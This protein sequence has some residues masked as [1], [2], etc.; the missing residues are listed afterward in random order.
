VSWKVDN[1][2]D[3]KET[4]SENQQVDLRM[5]SAAV[6]ISLPRLGMCRTMV[7]PKPFRVIF[8]SLFAASMLAG[9]AAHTQAANRIT[10]AIDPAN[11]QMLANHHPLWAIPANDAGALPANQPIKNVT[12]VLARSAEQEQA[13]DQ[14]LNEQQNP[15]SPEFHHW[16]TPIEMGERFGV[17]DSDIAAIT[18][19][20]QSEGLHVDWVA[21]NRILIGFGGS[22]ANM[23]R[24]FQTEFHYYKIHGQQRMSPATDPMIPTGVAPVIKA[25]R[26]LYTVE[27]RPYHL[28]TP[29]HADA[30]EMTVTNGSE[31]EHFVAP[32]DFDAIY[33]VPPSITGAG[34][35]I[36]IVGESRTD[37]ADFTNF[38]QL[39]G[40]TF[41][42]PTEI[43]PTT[44]GGTD[45][46]T[47]YT[48]P[49]SCETTDTCTQAVD[50]LLDAQGEAT[51]D[52]FRS[53]SVAPGASILLVT[54]SAASGGIGDDVDYLVDTTPAPAQVISISFGACEVEAGANN[55]DFWDALFKTA[56]GEGISVFVASGD[57]GASGCDAY[58]QT[59]PTD[60]EP[61]SPN[62]ICSSSYATCVG[63]TEFADASNPAAY[64]SSSDNAYLT[65]ALGYIP[66]GAWNE[67]INSGGGT[68][69]A[70]TGGGVSAYIATP[71]W[72]TGN[73]VPSSR[74]GRYTPDVAFSAAGHDGYFGC[75]AA[76]GGNCVSGSD[77]FT[78]IVFSG[79]SA[80]APSMAGVA[81]LLDQKQGSGQGNLNPEIYSLAASTPAAFHAVSIASSGVSDCSVT[82]PSMCNNSIPSPTALTGGQAGYSL[83]ATG[84]YSEVT[85][86]G[87]L[88]VAQ[89]IDDYSSSATQITPTVSLSVP[90][91]TINTTQSLL[92]LVT[93]NGGTGNPAPTG[94]ITLT[95][96]TFS[97]QAGLSDAS[98]STNSVTLTVPA[99]SLAVGTDTLTATYTSISS[100]YSNAT[101]TATVTVTSSSKT[102]PAISWS[103]PSAI[104]YGTA[105]SATQLD[106]TT[107]VAGNFSYSPAAGAVLTAGQQTLSVTFTPTDTTDYNNATATVTLTVNKATP[108][109]SW[110]TPSPITYGTALG[111]AQLDATASTAGAINYSPAAGTVLTAGLQTLAASFAPSDTTD[112]NPA[113]GSVTLTVNK[114]TPVI[115]WAAPAAVSAG[116]AL[117]STQLDATASV[118]GV[119]VYSPAAGAVMSIVGSATLS[120][121]F[122]PNDSTDY[123]T[124]TDSVTLVVNTPVNPSFALGGTNVSLAPGSTTGDTSTITVTPAGG[125]TGSVTLTAAITQSPTGVADA[126]T[127]SF[128]STSPL[129]ISGSNAGT[130]TL[131]ITT[132]A[133][134]TSA[135]RLANPAARLRAA[136]GAALA[137]VLL[138][139]LP[140]RRRGW[141]NLLGMAVL[142]AALACG[143]TACGG[144]AANGGAD[145]GG[146]GGGGGG[147]NGNPGTTAGTYTITVTGASG[148]TNVT[149]TI[150]LTVT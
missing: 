27:D 107:S 104:T 105:L 68:Q 119:F 89:F 47:A 64:W 75:F 63:G 12:L 57:A 43:I 150:T 114:A 134:T 143:M 2:Q 39:T 131:T 54:A 129:T 55:V 120:V 100:T 109:V 56:V 111:A 3:S 108:T 17:S 45:P 40:S 14:L 21:S 97:T 144:G 88:D 145:G 10:Q 65:S 33:D 31:T 13:L 116:T 115:T 72:Q 139:W 67:P 122:T 133:A 4:T 126:P 42:D 61:N 101:G 8:F 58:F 26:G 62:Y 106:A 87:S 5:W 35:T 83:G 80:A 121:T 15:A 148:S 81:A 130:A 147:G 84:G 141:R 137:C 138:F 85:G 20:L 98:G 41:P 70:A 132:T 82:T 142:L 69:A 66:E 50:S 48:A 7:S 140:V 51:L 46:G 1:S 90:G 127:L 113:T 71:S 22:A 92:V 44:Y 6:F 9:E 25:V 52:V 36:G 18:G 11:V 112:Y 77:G 124:A 102:T 79:T 118:P 93:V 59:P 34:M 60:P 24:A 149:T 117:S 37:M 128:G 91:Q 99:G 125:F 94:S 76:G 16:L 110:A 123:T 73:G 28:S 78:F 29:M 146:G 49:P 95:S 103:A 38:K 53:G 96:G 23:G 30:P 32:G 74:Q 136:G 19:W 86:W 135:E